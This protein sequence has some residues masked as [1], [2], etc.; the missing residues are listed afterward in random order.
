MSTFD[1][2]VQVNLKG[3]I[4]NGLKV[5]LNIASSVK[6]V[7]STKADNVLVHVV[8]LLLTDTT[9]QPQR[10]PFSACS[11]I[12]SPQAT[13]ALRYQPEN[14]GGVVVAVLGLK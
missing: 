7:H 13:I 9:S 8:D 14:M 10:C 2:T 6:F 1:P 5:M 4:V 3:S 12:E 11:F